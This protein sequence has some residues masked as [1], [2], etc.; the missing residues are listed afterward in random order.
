MLDLIVGKVENVVNGFLIV[1]ITHVGTHNANIYYTYESI[2]ISNWENFNHL[3]YSQLPHQENLKNIFLHR[4]IEGRIRYR[5][6]YNILY[7]NVILK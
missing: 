6:E 3:Y 1:N 4:N 5:D 7:A 2:A